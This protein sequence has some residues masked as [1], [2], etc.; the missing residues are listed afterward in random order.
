MGSESTAHEAES[1]MGCGLGGH[2]GERN[3]NDNDNFISIAVY[4]K[5]EY[6][7]TN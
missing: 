2:E 5:A 7:F 4:T 3:N 6:R 1:R